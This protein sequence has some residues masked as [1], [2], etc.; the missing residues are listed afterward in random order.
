MIGGS[1]PR[2]HQKLWRAESAGGEKHLAFR[3]DC[4][5]RAAVSGRNLDADGAS[6]LNENAGRGRLGLD[7]Q[8]LS[9]ASRIDISAR[10]RGAAGVAL[11]KLIEA[12][13]V[14][15][16][17][18][19]VVIIRNAHFLGG[20]KISIADRQRRDRHRD[21]QRAAVRMIVVDEALIVLGAFEIGK[22]FAIAPT[23]ATVLFR[24][25]IVIESV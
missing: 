14:L 12:D 6:P 23:L 3:A 17:A 24:P 8:V 2:L 9:V 13:A 15:P 10:C 4:P 1:D 7:S 5:C 16:R 22:D 21:A 25:S 19:D 11:G 20:A 18:I